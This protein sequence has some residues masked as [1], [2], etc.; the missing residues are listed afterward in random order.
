MT[1]FSFWAPSIP[2]KWLK[3]Q[4]L[5]LVHRLMTR[6]PIQKFAKLGQMG[7]QPGSHDLLLNFGTPSIYGTAEDT[8]F[9][10]GIWID[11][12]EAYAKNCNIRSTGNR[13]GPL[14]SLRR[15]LSTS[16]VDY[17]VWHCVACIFSKCCQWLTASVAEPIWKPVSDFCYQFR[18]RKLDIGKPVPV[19]HP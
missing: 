10:L 18:I 9:K 1:Y 4:T 19:Y 17:S 8:N 2:M 3:I 14:P 15:Q 16:P 6:S 13:T 7:T 12:E 5:N 11:D